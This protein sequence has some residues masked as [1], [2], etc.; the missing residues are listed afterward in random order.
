MKN[1]II[2]VDFFDSFTYNIATEIYKMK[3]NV[4]VEQYSTKTFKSIENLK[5]KKIIILGPGPGHPED[6]STIYPNLK[7][8][9]R[10]KNLFFLG[11]CLG[12]QLLW[13]VQGEKIVKS[14]KPLHGIS[15][16]FI[17]PPWKEHFEEKDWGL[18]TH[19]QRYNSLAVDPSKKNRHNFSFS[20]GEVI[21]GKFERGLTYQFHPESI[22]TQRPDLFFN[23]LKKILIK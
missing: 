17:I 3:I 23:P 21:A 12:H 6:Y 15:V 11:I 19:V 2:I 9:L 14:K 20:N 4:Q 22:G 10:N 13:R 5:E 18:K 1:D 16:P 8:S 7:N